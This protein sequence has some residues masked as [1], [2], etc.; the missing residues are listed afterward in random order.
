MLLN[1]KATKRYA[2]E[3][4]EGRHHKFT[5]V[6]KELLDRAELKLREWIRNEVHSL[7]S[8]GRTIK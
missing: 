5:R 4:S 7:P 1:R 2:L 8:V 6:S 3:I